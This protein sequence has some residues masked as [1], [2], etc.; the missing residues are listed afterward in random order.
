MK[1][2]T[3]VI[4]AFYR[5]AQI[6]DAPQRAEFFR[7]KYPESAQFTISGT[8]CVRHVNTFYLGVQID[9]GRAFVRAIES[10]RLEDIP[11][12]NIES[13]FRNVPGYTGQG[14]IEVDL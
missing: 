13:L 14:W 7:T 6:E 8:A 3:E 5:S 11:A 12:G 10:D 9:D 4:D 2:L 1:R